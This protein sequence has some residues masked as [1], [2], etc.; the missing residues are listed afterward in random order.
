[1]GRCRGD[2]MFAEVSED[3][4]FNLW[5][6]RRGVPASDMV[7]RN[8]AGTIT[9]ANLFNARRRGSCDFTGPLA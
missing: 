6:V 8:I 7:C 2:V 3:N 4:L 9:V 5:V 1:M